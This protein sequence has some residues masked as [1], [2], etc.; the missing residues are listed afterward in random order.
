MLILNF[1]CDSLF[2]IHPKRLMYLFETH[3]RKASAPHARLLRMRP[4][5]VT[6]AMWEMGRAT[7]PSLLHP[8]QALHRS[9]G[10]HP[11]TDAKLAGRG[12]V[13]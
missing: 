5:S 12:S 1:K 8:R 2:I 4:A 6:P 7:Q 9:T 11:A 3:H 13:R 10:T